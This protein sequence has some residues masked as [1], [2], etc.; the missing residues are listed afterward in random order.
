MLLSVL[1]VSPPGRAAGSISRTATSSSS[2]TASTLDKSIQVVEIVVAR[3]GLMTI[4][5]IYYIIY[6][7]VPPPS[8]KW[9][10]KLINYRY[11]TY[12]P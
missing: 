10:Y 9:I 4:W 3:A 2:S 12:K 8:Y 11:I 7:V 5:D 1:R 6:K